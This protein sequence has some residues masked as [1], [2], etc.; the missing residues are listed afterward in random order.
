MWYVSI[1]PSLISTAVVVGDGEQFSI[2]NFCREKDSRNKKGWSKWFSYCEDLVQFNIIDYNKAEGYSDVEISKL[3]DYNKITESIVDEIVKLTRGEN[4][5]VFIEGFS[6]SSSAGDIIDL[7]TFST[8]LR[9]KLFSLTKDIT[10]VSPMT[11]KQLSCKLTYEPIDIGKKKPKLVWKNKSGI[12]GGHFTKREV[13]LSIVES[14]REDKWTRHC[15]MMAPEI[16]SM[17]SI[18]KPYEDCCDA[19]I[20]Y[21]ASYLLSETK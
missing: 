12:A 5:K 19:F 20:L 4:F 6:F 21:Q 3:Q 2:L 8:L 7:V 17:K 10:I 15:R 11:L 18:P 14:N 16:L 9:I 13:F 1:D